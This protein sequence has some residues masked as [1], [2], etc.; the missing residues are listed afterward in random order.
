MAGVREAVLKFEIAKVLKLGVE[1]MRSKPL[2]RARQTLGG[3]RNGK[4][5]V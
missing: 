3:K 4:K 1:K 5:H 2:A